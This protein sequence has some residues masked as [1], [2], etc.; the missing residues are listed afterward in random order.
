M[1]DILLPLD[2]LRLEI[3]EGLQTVKNLQLP[4]LRYLAAR[5]R[6]MDCYQRSVKWQATVQAATTS[7]SS[8]DADAAAADSDVTAPASLDCDAFRF[9]QTRNIKYQDMEEAM[10]YGTAP[11]RQLMRTQI[12]SAVDNLL[13]EIS[14]KLFSGTGN[15]ASGGIVGLATAAAATG[16]YAGIDQGTYS[17]WASPVN[18][19]SGTPR[20]LSRDLMR[21]L[22][23]AQFTVGG[24]YDLILVD[25]TISEKYEG[26]FDTGAGYQVQAQG[27]DV[28][29]TMGS[30]LF[31]KGRPLMR[32]KDC[33]SGVSYFVNTGNV[34]FHSRAFEGTE[35]EPTTGINILV[36]ELPSNN[37]NA[38]KM[39]VSAIVQLAVLSRRDI[40]VL[41]DLQ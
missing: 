15:Q 28:L 31:F 2:L 37:P 5:G 9:E 35:R 40:A 34:E 29:G 21:N 38:A 25:P 22:D 26:L 36:K 27:A 41:K 18:D 30:N 23:T 11:L 3:K 24:G 4:F 7:T 20:D 6:M 13:I 32:D 39:S 19:G 16:S 8:T 33:T 1:S 14:S 17:L 10:R 12:S